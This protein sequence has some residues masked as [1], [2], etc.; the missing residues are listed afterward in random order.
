MAPIVIFLEELRF[1]RNGRY[2]MNNQR[3]ERQSPAHHTG[4][5]QSLFTQS[6]NTH[7][8]L[9]LWVLHPQSQQTMDE[10][11]LI[12]NKETYICQHM[13]RCFILLL[14][15]KQFHMTTICI[16]FALYLVL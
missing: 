16:S 13:C 7:S 4:A 3:R 10:G 5:I 9:G 12:N 15:P 11:V 14:L 2:R 1:V 8:T 6:C